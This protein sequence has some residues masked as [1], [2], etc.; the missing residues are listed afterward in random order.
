MSLRNP[1]LAS[2]SVLIFSGLVGCAANQP[3]R[4]PLAASRAA[5]DS[6]YVMLP[7]NDDAAP[8]DN[9]EPQATIDENED[10]MAS[11]LAIPPGI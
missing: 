10:I 3:P 1:L 5:P 8:Q 2:T 9:P 7:P 11:I 6:E 4:A